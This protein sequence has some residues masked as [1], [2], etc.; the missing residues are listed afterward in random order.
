VPEAACLELLH[1]SIFALLY[2][3]LGSL[4]DHQVYKGEQQAAIWQRLNVQHQG[5]AALQQEAAE[6]QTQMEIGQ[7]RV[8]ALQQLEAPDKDQQLEVEDL[9]DHLEMARATKEQLL[10]QAADLSASYQ[11]ELV[12]QQTPELADRV[13]LWM[14]P[15]LPHLA[16]AVRLR[17]VGLASVRA[18]AEALVVLPADD[19]NTRVAVLLLLV[20]L[21]QMADPAVH[22][23]FLGTT[24]WQAVLGA[25]LELSCVPETSV[26]WH[27]LDG[28][29][30][31]SIASFLGQP[32][33]PTGTLVVGTHMT[34]CF[35]GGLT[36]QLMPS[37]L[38]QQ[39]PQQQQ[40]AAAAHDAAG[41]LV[42][43][44]APAPALPLPRLVKGAL[45]FPDGETLQGHDMHAVGGLE[46]LAA[47]L[48]C[49]PG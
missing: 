27:Q 42:P 6:L 46:L 33:P 17:P 47:V 5:I 40:P 9:Q 10:R 14:L 35:L 41:A 30:A 49:R 22:S 1:N 24:H 36:M 16:H 29:P 21:L 11:A 38:G 34:A 39:Q 31:N 23:A 48:G 43:V 26:T 15:T 18:V 8:R 28:S 37:V 4:C 13:V 7:Q 20:L 32:Q 12:Q 44:A 45:R 19:V 2:S 25:L 3:I